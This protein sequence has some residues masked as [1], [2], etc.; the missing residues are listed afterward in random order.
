LCRRGDQHKEE[1]LEG[2]VLT[3]GAV[4]KLWEVLGGRDAELW[5]C[6]EW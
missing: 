1:G 2:G 6:R 5:A 3:E 4:A